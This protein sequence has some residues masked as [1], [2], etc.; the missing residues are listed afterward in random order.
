VARG[1]RE[2]DEGMIDATRQY[3]D[4]YVL[5]VRVPAPVAEIMQGLVRRAV[6]GDVQAARELRGWLQVYPPE[7]PGDIEIGEIPRGLRNQL[8]QRLIHDTETRVAPGDSAQR[9][10]R[11]WHPKNRNPS[12][13]ARLEPESGLRSSPLGKRNR[14]SCGNHAVSRST[15]ET[16]P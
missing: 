11:T 15:P 9:A 13:G 10:A 12:R 2:K 8:L 7:E 14:R 5:W 4:D 3:P 1:Q 16:P 6:K